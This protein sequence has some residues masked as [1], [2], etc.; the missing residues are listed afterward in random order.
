MSRKYQIFCLECLIN[1]CSIPGIFEETRLANKPLISQCFHIVDEAGAN[2]ISQVEVG[3]KL[4]LNKLLS[5]MLLKTLLKNE[6]I[7]C[8]GAED[9]K[10]R[11]FKLVY[12]FAC[13]VV[14][15]FKY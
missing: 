2:G 3:R 7:V 12:C 10:K 6:A 11:Y 1:W 15:L 8:A 13:V 14:R 9:A 5:R 4:G